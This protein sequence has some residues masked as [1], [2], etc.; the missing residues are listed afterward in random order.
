MQAPLPPPP[1]PLDLNGQ[2]MGGRRIGEKLPVQDLLLI[3]AVVI[4]RRRVDD[5]VVLRLVG[6]DHHLAGAAAPAARPAAWVRS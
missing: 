2:D 5:A 3:K 1:A 4:L 6:L